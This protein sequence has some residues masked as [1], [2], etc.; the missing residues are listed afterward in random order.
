MCVQIQCNIFTRWDINP[1]FID[2]ANSFCLICFAECGN[3]KIS[4]YIAQQSNSIA[5]FCRP[6][7]ITDRL[8]FF[9]PMQ[10]S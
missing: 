7:G 5:I 10:A 2:T 8:I 6:Q 3:L 4:V 1:A 9:S